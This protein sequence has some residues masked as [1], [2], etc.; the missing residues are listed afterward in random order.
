MKPVGWCSRGIGSRVV[1]SV[2]WAA[3]GLLFA[4]SD[5]ERSDETDEGGT[6]A[7][8]VD[9]LMR[10]AAAANDCGAGHADAGGPSAPDAGRLSSRPGDRCGPSGEGDLPYAPCDAKRGLECQQPP[11]SQIDAPATCGCPAE[12]TFSEPQQRCVAR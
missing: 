2:G 3:L 9:K 1:G 10:D 8:R 5:V 11:R 6:V 4:C 7:P 12:Q